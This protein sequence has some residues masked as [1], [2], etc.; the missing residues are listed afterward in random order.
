MKLAIGLAHGFIFG[1][2]YVQFV[3][4]CVCVLLLRICVH[5]C[6]QV[7]MR[8]DTQRSE[9]QKLS[10]STFLCHSPHYF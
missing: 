1:V 6:A 5:I 3:C 4:V 8:V 7:H 9:R 2:W 10:L